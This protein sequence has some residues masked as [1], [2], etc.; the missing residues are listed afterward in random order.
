MCVPRAHRPDLGDWFENGV[1]CG[2]WWLVGV[3]GHLTEL[4]RLK[5]WSIQ[6]KRVREIG[7][8]GF[9]LMQYGP[10]NWAQVD[11]SASI[12]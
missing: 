10:T 3:K 9:I 1:V 8:D 12:W 11:K 4:V 2:W 7:A 6:R 5:N